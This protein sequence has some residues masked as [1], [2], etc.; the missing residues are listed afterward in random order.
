VTNWRYSDPPQVFAYLSAYHLSSPVTP[1]PHPGASP[2]PQSGRLAANLGRS[3]GGRGP[4]G[5]PLAG[6]VRCATI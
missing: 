5:D 1:G 3:M 2:M 4:W 6:T